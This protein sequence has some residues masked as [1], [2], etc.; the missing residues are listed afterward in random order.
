MTCRPYS[1]QP[2]QGVQHF[3]FSRGVRSKQLA[4]RADGLS[5]CTTAGDR[6]RRIATMLRASCPNALYALGRL[7]AR[8]LAAVHST[9]AIRHCRRSTGRAS[10]GLASTARS[11]VGVTG[12][13]A[14]SEPATASQDVAPH[15]VYGS[16][17]ALPP[18]LT[19][20]TLHAAGG[21][22]SLP[23]SS[24]R[25]RPRE[26]MLHSRSQVEGVVHDI[27][28]LSSARRGMRATGREGHAA[29]SFESIVQYKG[30]NPTRGTV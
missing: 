26:P 9:S 24:S 21:H 18:G 17:P 10:A 28:R 13:A 14:I 29:G 11:V 4:N 5:C 27:R 16:F 23:A 19:P 30:M 2:C 3:F 8:R 7:G 1:S 6:G 22:D 20:P 12:R 25:R 15:G